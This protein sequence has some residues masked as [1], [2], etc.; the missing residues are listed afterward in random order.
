MNPPSRANLF[1]LSNITHIDC[2]AKGLSIGIH[3]APRGTA[4]ARNLTQN[5]LCHIT[6]IDCPAKGLSIGI[7]CAPRGTATAR[8]LTQNTLC[9]ITHIVSLLLLCVSRYA[10][11]AKNSH[12]TQSYSKCVDSYH[13]CCEP[14]APLHILI[15]GGRKKLT[16]HAI[17]SKYICIISRTLTVP[18]GA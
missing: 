17:Y 2:P 9:H 15:R 16:L 3:C 7:H 6:H 5:T 1:I 18:R 4:T 12:C 13:E 14:F 8:N 10:A 11:V